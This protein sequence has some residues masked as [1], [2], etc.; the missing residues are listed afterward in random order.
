MP[1]VR[2]GVTVCVRRYDTGGPGKQDHSKAIKWY[3]EA[4]KQDSASGQFN[5]GRM[6]DQ[7]RG[8]KQDAKQAV[9]WHAHPWLDEMYPMF[10]MG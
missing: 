9:K 4:A 3:R 6:Y 8:V 2:N 10:C 5:L 7:G 1:F